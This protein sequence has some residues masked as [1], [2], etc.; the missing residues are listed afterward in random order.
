VIAQILET[1]GSTIGGIFLFVW[2]I[3][4]IRD[5]FSKYHSN[6]YFQPTTRKSRAERVF[7]GL[8]GL[9]CGVMGIGMVV[10]LI[11]RALKVWIY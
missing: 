8:F 4:I 1:A 11:T 7:Y 5:C 2:S 6:F 3:N 10:V 9:V